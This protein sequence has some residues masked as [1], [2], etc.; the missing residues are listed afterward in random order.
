MSLSGVLIYIQEVEEISEDK[1][2]VSIV[3]YRSGLGAIFPKY[4]LIFK[5][6]KW[7]IETLSMGIS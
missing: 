7:E 5:N 6:G 4:E 3:K 1:A 2:V